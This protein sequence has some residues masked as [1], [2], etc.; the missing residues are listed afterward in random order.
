[1]DVVYRN[2][3]MIQNHFAG[4]KRSGTLKLERILPAKSSVMFLVTQKG[5]KKKYGRCE[6][7][8][9]LRGKTPLD[10]KSNAL[11]TRPS[12]LLF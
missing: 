11:T 6:Q 2:G 8:S 9:N 7:D 4:I 5:Q 3:H 12:Q 1:M 10:F